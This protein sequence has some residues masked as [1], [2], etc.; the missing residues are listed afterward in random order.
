M[1]EARHLS[2]RRVE[3]VRWTISSVMLAHFLLGLLASVGAVAP[4]TGL[5]LASPVVI[6]RATQQAV[7]RRRSTVTR[8][9]AACL[10]T[11]KS[12]K[13]RVKLKGIACVAGW[14]PS[15]GADG[16]R[17]A[18]ERLALETYA[19]PALAAH[20]AAAPPHADSA[21]ASQHSATPLEEALLSLEADRRLSTRRPNAL[22]TTLFHRISHR[23]SHAARRGLLPALSDARRA[24]ARALPDLRAILPG[25]TLALALASVAE[26]ISHKANVF[27]PFLWASL[28]GMGAGNALSALG[29]E[30]KDR[31]S[32]GIM[33]AKTRLLRTGI[34]LY[35]SKLTLQSLAFTG[36]AGILTDLIT[37]SS[38]LALGW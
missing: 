35:G 31:F 27:S 18:G 13:P 1:N 25:V 26:V 15:S 6:Y 36:V 19:E 8:V 30:T 37:T 28:I 2:P 12:L 20:T 7:C 22:T 17:G 4:A 24:T 16:Q 23:I 21:H 10:L 38:T 3:K 33:F 29:P 34:I 32:S 11:C 9:P 5:A 14:A